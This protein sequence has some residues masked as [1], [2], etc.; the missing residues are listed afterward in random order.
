MA[1]KMLQILVTVELL[2]LKYICCWHCYLC[3]DLDVIG[4]SV[5]IFTRQPAF[6]WFDA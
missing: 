1:W 6:S 4:W 5:E 2:V 3:S